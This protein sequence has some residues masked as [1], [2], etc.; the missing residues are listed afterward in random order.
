M[1]TIHQTGHGDACTKG[2]NENLEN[3]IVANL[4]AALEIDGNQCFV[5]PVIFVAILISNTT[6]VAYPFREKRAMD[7]LEHEI[8]HV[9]YLI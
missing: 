2:L 8:C 9:A 4:A 6:A 1:A 7:V 3:V 5:I